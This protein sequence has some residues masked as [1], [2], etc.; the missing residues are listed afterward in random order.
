LKTVKAEKRAGNWTPDGKAERAALRR[1]YL[2]LTPAQRAE[3]VFDLS[4][5]MS[6]VAQAGRRQRGG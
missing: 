2:D 4:R 6:Q 1:D 3:Q 5:F